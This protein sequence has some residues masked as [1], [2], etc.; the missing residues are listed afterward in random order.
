MFD[1]DDVEVAEIGEIIDQWYIGKVQDVIQY[2]RKHAEWKVKDGLLYRHKRN[3]L[4]DP[5]TDGGEGWR[6]VVPLEKRKRVLHDS[7]C[8]TSAGHLGVDKTY[9]RVAREYF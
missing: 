5:F 6:M 3:P 1:E 7:H 8:I 9:D 4:L 2:Q